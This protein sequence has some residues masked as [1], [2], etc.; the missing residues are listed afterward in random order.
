MI[1]KAIMVPHPP[2]ALAEVG[3]E[4]SVMVNNAP[5]GEDAEAC[6]ALGAALV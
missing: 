1:V 5:E 2:I 4:E 6:K 3:S